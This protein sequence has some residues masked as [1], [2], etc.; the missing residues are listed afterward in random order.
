MFLLEI[1]DNYV[2]RIGNNIKKKTYNFL[3]RDVYN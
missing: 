2:Y 1:L 3:V